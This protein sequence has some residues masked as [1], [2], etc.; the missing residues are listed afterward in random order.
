MI[1]LSIILSNR[2]ISTE[3]LSLIGHICLCGK[4]FEDILIP[5]LDNGKQ[6]IKIESPSKLRK[7]VLENI[8]SLSLE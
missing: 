4:N 6:I 1:Y 5:V 8:K 2:Q 7:M 3:D